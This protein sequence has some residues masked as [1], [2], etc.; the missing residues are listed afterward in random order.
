MKRTAYVLAPRLSVVFQRILCLGSSLPGDRP[1]SPQFQKV[2]RPPLLPIT[3]QFPQHQY[4][5]RCFSVWWRFVSENLWNTVVCFQP[6]S[7]HIGKIWVP[8][9]HFC[10]CHIHCRV[11]WRV[12]RRP[13]IVQIDFSAAF[14]RVNHKGILYKLSSVSIGGSV[15]SVLT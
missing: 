15:L 3:E 2:H 10:V 11:H 8:V 4:Y 1:M 5:P 6:P 7:L 9:M 12:G 13:L 14:D